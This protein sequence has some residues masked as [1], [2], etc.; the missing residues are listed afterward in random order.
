MK[1]ENAMKTLK[2][3]LCLAVLSLV[4]VGQANANNE[5][6][7]VTFYWNA[8]VFEQGDITQCFKGTQITRVKYDKESLSLTFWMYNKGGTFK[9]EFP[10]SQR[11]YFKKIVL[12]ISMYLFGGQNKKGTPYD[13]SKP[14]AQK[15][16][17]Q[18]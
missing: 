4:M 2:I 14:Y 6:I 3:A 7:K 9:Y 10:K 8:V 11:D 5:K 1:G 13:P 18:W 15:P 12:K 17:S 16:H